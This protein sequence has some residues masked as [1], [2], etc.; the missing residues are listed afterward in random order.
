MLTASS[1]LQ[2]AS[3]PPSASPAR[4]TFF[5]VALYLLAVAQG[6]YGPCGEA[7]GADQ[8]A[9]SDGDDPSTPAFRSSYF[10]WFH[11]SIS[12]GYAI[13]SAGLSYVQDNAGWTVGFG[14][15]WAAMALCLAVFLLGTPAYRAKQPADGGPFAETVR[16]W[17]ASVFR[18]KDGATGIRSER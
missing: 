17:V 6:F 1:M 5:Y 18:R 2:T 11:F 15:C 14:A 13:A 10:N 16:A 12:W 3:S 9:P 8:L 4:L 7:F